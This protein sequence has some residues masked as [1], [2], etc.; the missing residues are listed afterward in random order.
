MAVPIGAA[1]VAQLGVGQGVADRDPPRTGGLGRDLDDDLD[2]R[3]RQP[4]VE[5]PRRQGPDRRQPIGDR[6]GDAGG[7]RR[8]DL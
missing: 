1:G 3:R 5:L 4:Q 2:H 7:R 6:D 8:A